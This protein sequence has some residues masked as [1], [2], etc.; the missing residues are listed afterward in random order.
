ML[1]VPF[2]RDV[3]RN[4]MPKLPL[5]GSQRRFRSMS[6]GTVPKAASRE[7]RD[8][9]NMENTERGCIHGILAGR[10]SNSGSSAG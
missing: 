7:E 5:R 9:A 8:L 4:R 2:K 10:A 1:L 3:Q 6:D